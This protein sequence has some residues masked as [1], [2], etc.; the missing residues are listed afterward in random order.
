MVSNGGGQVFVVLLGVTGCVPHGAKYG[1]AVL[2]EQRGHGHTHDHDFPEVKAKAV[3]HGLIRVNTGFELQ[4]GCHGAP[5]IINDD[6]L[7]G[8]TG[9]ELELTV[10][11][12]DLNAA[13]DALPVCVGKHG[14]EVGNHSGLRV[15]PT[16]A[17]A[18]V[19]HF[20]TA[21][22]A[23][24]GLRNCCPCR[25]CLESGAACACSGHGD[26]GGFG[27]G[28]RRHICGKGGCLR[29]RGENAGC[30]QQLSRHGASCREVE[31]DTAAVVNADG[32][33]KGSN[34]EA[35]VAAPC[36]QARKSTTANNK[37]QQ[38]RRME[39]RRGAF[40]R[41]QSGT[42]QQEK[43]REGQRETAMG[44]ERREGGE[45]REERRE[46]GERERE[47]EER[48]RTNEQINERINQ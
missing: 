27:C 23:S 12:Q 41:K 18:E 32:K 4:Q 43:Q 48:E 46:K 7:A 24:H 40:Q 8:I 33:G 5:A 13:S 25:A 6:L 22:V 1:T 20:D 35:A 39:A 30:S 19:F 26:H 29:K 42:K 3:E 14:K 37:L 16:R 44:E 36:G 45:E 2:V 11:A 34:A 17:R 38:G 21:A 47:R 9:A 10:R 31:N 15:A 28:S